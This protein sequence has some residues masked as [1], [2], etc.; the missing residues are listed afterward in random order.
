VALDAQEYHHPL[1]NKKEDPLP[2]HPSFLAQ[3]TLQTVTPMK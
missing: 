1:E 3:T 2:S